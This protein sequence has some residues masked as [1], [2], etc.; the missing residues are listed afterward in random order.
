MYQTQ[1]TSVANK[2]QKIKKFSITETKFASCPHALY[3]FESVNWIFWAASYFD[4]HHKPYIF[5]SRRSQQNLI[6]WLF[7]GWLIYRIIPNKDVCALKHSLSIFCALFIYLFIVNWVS[8]GPRYLKDKE[9]RVQRVIIKMHLS[10][11]KNPRP[12]QK[13]IKNF[14]L[15]SNI[16]KIKQ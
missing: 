13:Y 10:F 15:H 9:L 8:S 5:S 11:I 12:H 16:V 1:D 14:L 6:W 4:L 3:I 2:S 7:T